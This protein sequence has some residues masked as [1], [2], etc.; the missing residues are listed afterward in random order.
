MQR[1][2]LPLLSITLLMVA[3]YPVSS[4]ATTAIFTWQ[5]SLPSLADAESE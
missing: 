4:A 1:F 5:A 2:S 3:I